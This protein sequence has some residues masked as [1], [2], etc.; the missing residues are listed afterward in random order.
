MINICGSNSLSGSFGVTG[1]SGVTGSVGHPGV[2]GSPGIAPDYK[3]ALF[4]CKKSYG[5]FEEDRYYKFLF[6]SVIG[7]YYIKSKDGKFEK[8][9][10]SDEIS[11]HFIWGPELRD[12]KL[13]Q[14][15]TTSQI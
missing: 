6:Y 3:E 12:K 7:L 5:F 8:A 9:I 1:V 2:C 4:Y 14:I 15:F 13:N 10:S 11:E